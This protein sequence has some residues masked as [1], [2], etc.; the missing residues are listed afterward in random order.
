MPYLHWERAEDFQTLEAIIGDKKKMKLSGESG[1]PDEEK[2]KR[3]GEN[4]LSVDKRAPLHLSRAQ[5]SP[6]LPTDTGSVLLPYPS[7]H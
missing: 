5:L 3:T 1:I 4:P 2:G 6:S 7:E